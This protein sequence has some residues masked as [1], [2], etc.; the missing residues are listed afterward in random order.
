MWKGIIQIKKYVIKRSE[1]EDATQCHCKNNCS[2]ENFFG[3]HR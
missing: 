3:A 1:R 2:T